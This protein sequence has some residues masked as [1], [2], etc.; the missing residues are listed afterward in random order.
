M[1]ETCENDI[2]ELPFEAFQ[3]TMA[4]LR[5][6][7]G[8]KY[9]FILKGGEGLQMA[10]Y[11]LMCIVWKSEKIPSAWLES[12]ST[13]LPKSQNKVGIL[14]SMRHIHEKNDLFKVL[15]QL[16]M[17]FAKPIIFQNMS[18]FQI[19]S[20]PGHRPSEH[21]FVIKSVLSYYESKGKCVI[22][23]SFDLQKYYDSEQLKDCMMELYNSQITG[24]LYRLIFNMNK[25]VCIKVKTPVG[26]SASE[27]IHEIVAQ[28]SMDS[29]PI[30]ANN[31][32]KGIDV[33][34][35]DSDGEVDYLGLQLAPLILMDDIA[36]MTDNIESA[37]DG[38]RRMEHLLDSKCLKFNTVKSKFLVMG[39]KKGRNK[40]RKQ[41]EENSIS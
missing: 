1:L 40:I 22:F 19:A 41:I 3:E 9:D 10:L 24:K 32:S 14:D 29:G 30:S 37:Q 38:N 33:T 23:S 20:K 8:N 31:I 28:G 4:M 34:F 36:R 12:T 5:K 25:T 26:V 2:D 39:T 21:L 35:A 16:V 17:Y 11:N 6:K 18:K 7:N 15:G 27:E 13:Q